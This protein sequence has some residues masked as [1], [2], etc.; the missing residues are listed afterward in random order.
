[1]ALTPKREAFAQLLAASPPIS[2]IEAYRQTHDVFPDASPATHYEEASRIAALPEVAARIQELKGQY[3]KA[4]VSAQAWNLDQLV[5]QAVVNLQLSR[6]H[7]QLGSANG[8]L[9]II[10]RATGL[11]SDKARE[12]PQVPI[13]RVVIVLHEGQ[14]PQG[15][16]RITEAA[17]EVL[18]AGD[19]REDETTG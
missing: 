4:M 16:P 1:M 10:G 6:A 12:T 5:S 8:A 18:P 13:T 15:R 19:E 17:Y 9:E 11:L 14:D 2:Q 7:K 3:Q